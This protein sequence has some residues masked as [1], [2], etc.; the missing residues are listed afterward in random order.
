MTNLANFLFHE[1]LARIHAEADMSE[2]ELRDPKK[3]KQMIA[4]YNK[5]TPSNS[6]Q[7]PRYDRDNQ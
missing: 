3:L 7:T 4:K 5:Y 6:T 1:R 2:E